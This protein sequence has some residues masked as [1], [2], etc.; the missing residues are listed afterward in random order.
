M[1]C[2]RSEWIAASLLLLLTAVV[3]LPALFC[4]YVYFDD[5]TYVYKNPYVLSGLSLE[6]L[7]WAL[8][9]HYGFRSPLLWVSYMLDSTWLA[10]EPWAFHLTNVLL[11]AGSAAL[12]YLLLVRMTRRPGLSF[13]AASFW[14][15]HPL[16]VESVVWITER[17][18]VLSG[19]FFFLA[20]HA[21]VSF[22]RN[23]R[24]LPYLLLFLF[25]TAGLMVKPVLVTLPM[26]LLLLD[27]WPLEMFSN[28]W[29]ERIIEKI[30]LF[31]CAFFFTAT[32]WL[33]HR[34]AMSTF[35]TFSLSDRIVTA[36]YNYTI[37][38]CHTLWP[39]GLAAPY[40]MAMAPLAQAAVFAV[41]L[42]I[43]T[44]AASF[45]VRRVPW[46]FSGWLWFGIALAPVCGLIQIGNTTMADRFTYLPSIGLTVA[47]VWSVACLKRLPFKKEIAVVLVAALVLLT[48]RQI[49]FWRN[50]D[51][52]FQRTLAVTSNN[53]VAHVH[54]GGWLTEQGRL[55]EAGPHLLRA[56]EL[57]PEY[58]PAMNN[59]GLWL[60][61]RGDIQRSLVCFE[62]AVSNPSHSR[63]SELNLEA[64]RQVIN[65]QR[66]GL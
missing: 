33:A 4:G 26:L 48:I 9:E 8:E 39:L 57:F 66:E 10:P 51:T 47:L 46:M 2:L 6:S 1:K 64:C 59:L 36:V 24:C 34:G 58:S 25:M 56:V 32:G 62:A 45:S 41:A 50:S 18:D 43:L 17:K 23:R 11:H 3:F 38:L 20:L 22:S 27:V 55:D 30:P 40:P 19:L 63:Q 44:L 7:R 54:Y 5:P 52:F 61:K 31:I 21:Y 65:R 49:G 42:I 14:A 60:F 28:H 29:K 16:R 15:L 53:S 12:L 13:V 35:E 37:Y